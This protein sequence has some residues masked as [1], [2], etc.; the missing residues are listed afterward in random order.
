MIGKRWRVVHLKSARGQE[1][2]GQTVTVRNFD[3]STTDARLHCE[4]ESGEM[5]KLKNC[6]LL[7]SD[8]YE[9]VETFMS[10][11]QPIPNETLAKCV[12]KAL[13]QHSYVTDRKD[14]EHRLGLYRALLEKLEKSKRKLEDQDYCFPCGAG[15]EALLK[16]SGDNF[17]IIM[18]TMKPA[19]FGNEVVDMRHI[20]V[21]L[22]GDD[23]TE[24]SVCQETLKHD[25]TAVLV[26]LPCLHVFHDACLVEWLGSDIGQRHWSCP[27]CRKVVPED[28][29]TYRVDYMEQLQRRVNEYPVS[30]FCAK[31]MILIMENNRNAEL[32]HG[33]LHGE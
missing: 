10:K 16:D 9:M 25:T 18:N 6:N 8:A 17:G 5:I 1:L 22:V 32:G 30:G 12:R 20:D 31:C 13:E 14:L 19:C 7:A 29:S 11:S 3:R 26:T 15:S 24:C 33:T 21:G 2:N 28:L 4:F 23:S 27:T